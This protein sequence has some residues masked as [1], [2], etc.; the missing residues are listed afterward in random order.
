MKNMESKKLSKEARTAK[1]W[2]NSEKL[3]EMFSNSIYLT[4]NKKHMVLDFLKVHK[5][6]VNYK[7][8]PSDNTLLYHAVC[9][10][11]SE[12]AD[13]LIAHGADVNLGNCKNKISLLRAAAYGHLEM[14]I[15]SYVE[16]Q[17]LEKEISSVDLTKNSA[18]KIKV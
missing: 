15:D 9:V 13:Y 12:M 6:D 16:K 14:L 3:V 4:Q 8:H 5:I 1:L 11:F 17:L 2:K 7:L 10:D 18:T